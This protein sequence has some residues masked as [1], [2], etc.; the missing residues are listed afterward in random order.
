MTCYYEFLSLILIIH[1]FII[2]DKWRIHMTEEE[3]N[4]FIE[5]NI[6]LVHSRIKVLEPNAYKNQDYYNDLFQSGVVGFIEGMNHYIMN[7]D[8]TETTYSVY[9]IDAMIKEFKRK[10]RMIIMPQ[11]K[12]IKAIQF[13]F[14]Y[15]EL[16]YSDNEIKSTMCL[17]DKEF[18]QYKSLSKLLTTQRDDRQN[19][20]DY[21]K[22][23]YPEYELEKKEKQYY[24]NKAMNCLTEKERD[25]IKSIFGYECDEKSMKEL[26]RERNITRQAICKE[27]KKILKKLKINLIEYVS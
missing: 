23:H 9:W 15:E 16:Y 11:S 1:I 12:Y 21:N 5:D 14:Y 13:K 25:L 26:G 20:R 10:N 7:G 19:A 18:E 27:K 24:L 22:S 2:K 4:K 17:T 3:R 8:C 6:G